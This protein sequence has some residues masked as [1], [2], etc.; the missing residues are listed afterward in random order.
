METQ[1][2]RSQHPCKRRMA[3][4]ISATVLNFHPQLMVTLKTIIDLDGKAIH[5]AWSL[6]TMKALSGCRN[7]P[8]GNEEE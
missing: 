3:Q 5:A 6:E 7:E 2:N 1:Q 8:H 4:Q